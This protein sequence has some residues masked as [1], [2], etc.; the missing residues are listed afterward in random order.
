MLNSEYQRV[1]DLKKRVIDPAVLQINEF[2]DL[3]VSYTQKKKG[4]TVTHFI[5]NFSQ[6]ATLKQQF[7]VNILTI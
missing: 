3:T 6:K 2:S 1:L 5:F 4:R 7:P